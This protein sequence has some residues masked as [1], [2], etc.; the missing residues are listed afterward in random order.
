MAAMLIRPGGSI[1]F[2]ATVL[3]AQA[4]SA[5]INAA[6]PP[7]APAVPAPTDIAPANTPTTLPPATAAGIP[8]LYENVSF[9]IPEGL[10]NGATPALKPLLNNPGAFPGENGPAHP[11]FVLDGYA[12]GNFQAKEYSALQ[13]RAVDSLARLEAIRNDPA[14]LLTTNTLPELPDDN[15]RTSFAVHPQVL[16]FQ[17]GTGVRFLARQSPFAVMPVEDGSV[18][19]EY[20]GL[21]DDGK[22]LVVATF[23]LHVPFLGSN[24]VPFPEASASSAD[25]DD[26]YRKILENLNAMPENA[27]TPP[28]AWLD[29][30]IQSLQIS[31]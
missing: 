24:A 28:L 17:N 2:Y 3:V 18:F 15:R 10:A 1:V 9:I 22:F 6:N 20:Q 8:V 30:L 11:E 12:P 5:Q 16:A 31:P 29:A 21:T 25:Y 27:Y 7:P 4:C 14:T 23:T 26:Y 19:Y 13:P